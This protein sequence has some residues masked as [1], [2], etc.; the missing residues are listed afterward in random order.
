MLWKP[1]FRTREY[2]RTSLWVIPILFTL[3]AIVLGE[4][5]ATVDASF[6]N[7]ETL[8]NQATA[9]DVLTAIATGMIAFTGFVFSMLLLAVQFGSQAF[10]PRLLQFLRQRRIPKV[11]LGFFVATFTYAL[12]VLTSVGFGD[13]RF[14]PSLAVLV[15]LLLLFASVVLFIAMV[16]TLTASLRAATVLRSVGRRG[17]RVIASTTLPAGGDEAPPEEGDVEVV[18]QDGNP[19]VVQAFNL[20]GALRAA[21]GARVELVPAVGDFV[22]TAAP[23]FRISGG[24]APG[25]ALR[26]TVVL[27]DER[28]LTQDP[29]FAFRLLVDIAIKALSPAV[30]DP[31]TAVQALDQAEDLLRRL[32]VAPLGALWLRNDAGGGLLVRTPAWEDYLDLAL[33]EIRHYGRDSFQVLRRMRALLD[34]L[35][36]VAPAERQA[37]IAIKRALVDAA[38]ERSF[39]DADDRRVASVSDPQGLGVA[40]QR[41]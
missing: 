15:A 17:R 1:I 10:S 14:V 37:A 18:T 4:W 25:R 35:D 40:L 30:N 9:R 23:L 36:A 22:S 3:L 41:A 20:V 7:S 5:L 39:P 2:L 12:N 6:R 28:T 32:A 26:A 21:R 19:G 11:A 38:V 13:E 24:T 34:R 8:I 33:D 16:H 31:T 27:G 29:A